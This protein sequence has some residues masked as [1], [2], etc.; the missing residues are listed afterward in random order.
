MKLQRKLPVELHLDYHQ[1]YGFIMAHEDFPVG[2]PIEKE[3]FFPHPFAIYCLQPG[4]LAR[5]KKTGFPI[6]PKGFGEMGMAGADG[7]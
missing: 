6:I 3:G 7:K 5:V 2:K 4:T 1:I